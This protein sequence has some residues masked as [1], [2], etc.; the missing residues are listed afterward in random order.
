L[1]EA[2]IDTGDLQKALFE[3]EAG[4]Q[5]GPRILQ[6]YYAVAVVLIDLNQLPEA[7]AVLK[8]A[9]DNGLDGPG[10]HERLLYI[11]FPE[12]DR[13]AQAREAE[14]FENNHSVNL[15]CCTRPIMTL[16]SAMQSRPGH[17][18]AKPQI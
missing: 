8:T 17:C 14:W 18:S 3:A 15:G 1:A 13:Q 2:Y 4:L 16:P 6:S 7:T 5:N 9:I 10:V 11:S 12:G